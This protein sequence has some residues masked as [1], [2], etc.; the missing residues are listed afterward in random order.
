MFGC[1]KD[2]NATPWDES[3]PEINRAPPLLH[4]A[5]RGSLLHLEMN[6]YI[7]IYIYIYVYTHVIRTYNINICNMHVYIYIYIYTHTYTFFAKYADMC[8]SRSDEV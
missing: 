2:P 4:A 5:E 3:C 6:M 7:Y 1:L 8:S